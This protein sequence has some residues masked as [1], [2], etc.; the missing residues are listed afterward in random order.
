MRKKRTNQV[1]MW[2]TDDELAL[3]DKLANDKGTPKST[4]LRITLLDYASRKGY[5]LPKDQVSG[6]APQHSS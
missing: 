2:L 1:S 5:V 6:E 3:L 4:M